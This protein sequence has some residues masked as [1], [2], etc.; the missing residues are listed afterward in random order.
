MAAVA[1][2]VER[3]VCNACKAVWFQP[4]TNGGCPSCH[5]GVTL[6][7]VKL[8]ADGSVVVAD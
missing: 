3:W 6:K 7:Q 5:G 8:N 4:D 2:T 1:K